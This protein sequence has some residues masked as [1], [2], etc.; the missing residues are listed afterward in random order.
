[1]EKILAALQSF[2]DEFR[3]AFTSEETAMMKRVFD[4][5]C[6][7]KDIQANDQDHRETLALVIL[8]ATKAHTTEAELLFLAQQAARNY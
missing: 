8:R 1:M 6:R 5:V 3:G 2:G 4:H 7:D